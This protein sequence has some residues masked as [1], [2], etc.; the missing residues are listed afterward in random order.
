VGRVSFN[1]FK[2][3]QSGGKAVYVSSIS[4]YEL[5]KIA[6]LT[7]RKKSSDKAYQR[8]LNE[9]RIGSILSFI[10]ENYSK[11]SH[12]IIFPT[13]LILATTLDIVEDKK[14]ENDKE[15][16]N[17][18][19]A[20]VASINEDTV[21]IKLNG[22]VIIITVPIPKKNLL[23]TNSQLL[24]R[25]HLSDESKPIFIVDGQH[26]FEAVRRFFIDHPSEDFEFPVILLLN[27]DIY[28][29]A[30]IF[31]NVNFN[32]KPVNK[33]LYYDIFGTLPDSR[34]D[35]RL[36]HYLVKN[37]NENND[38]PLKDM[39]KMLGVGKGIISLAY[40][41]ENLTLLFDKSDGIGLVTVYNAYIEGSEDYKKILTIFKNYFSFIKK[42][43]S[44]YWPKPDENGDYSAYKYKH[45]MLKT[46]GMYALLNAFDF[47]FN[48]KTYLDSW[49]DD[50]EFDKY[51][52]ERFKFVI[53]NKADLFSSESI[54]SKGG[55]IGL[56][57]KLFEQMNK[58]IKDTLK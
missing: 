51:F 38:S 42:N 13:P 4:F 30:K 29:Q 37:L 48:K 56:Q 45:I 17:K 16:E 54:Y 8:D 52:S 58:Y 43:L 20:A 22:E 23:L 53:A 55:G 2:I 25:E 15:N 32:Q 41:A 47:L 5:I 28:E 19:L 34:S 33:S 12:L 1:A 6:K 57:K 9:R 21:T 14:K 35:I 18:E 7:F 10:K 40:L 11:K 27:H 46:T 31:A 44:E 36:A 39:I 26:R 50:K 24:N 3:E 49:S